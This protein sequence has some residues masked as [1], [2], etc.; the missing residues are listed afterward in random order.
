VA[1]RAW[2]LQRRPSTIQH[3][4][5]RQN[6]PP[7][8][9]RRQQTCENKTICPRPPRPLPRRPRPHRPPRPPRH[10]TMTKVQLSKEQEVRNKIIS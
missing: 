6:P 7:I 1:T 9:A 4:E 3:H 10:P 2:D 5:V 8:L